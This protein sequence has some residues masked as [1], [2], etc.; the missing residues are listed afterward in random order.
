VFCGKT[1]DSEAPVNIRKAVPRARSFILVATNDT[2]A[3][4]ATLGALVGNRLLAVVF[5]FLILGSKD[6]LNA[7]YSLTCGVEKTLIPLKSVC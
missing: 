7:F 4:G 1:F 6:Y 3:A 2:V 5:L